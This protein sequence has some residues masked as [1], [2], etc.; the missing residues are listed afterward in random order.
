MPNVLRP[1]RKVV[2]SNWES[3][4]KIVKKVAK[5]T[6]Q[7][8]VPKKAQKKAQRTS[9]GRMIFPDKMRLWALMQADDYSRWVAAEVL[10]QTRHEA[11]W[12]FHQHY[13]YPSQED[14]REGLSLTGTDQDK[15]LSIC[16][17]G[18]LSLPYVLA[19]KPHEVRETCGLFEYTDS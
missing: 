3:T 17:L 13:G 14:L 10:A 19:M 2:R 1:T 5:P 12:L 15:Y 8:I 4:G 18:G 16:E 9:S 6:E 7:L 11:V